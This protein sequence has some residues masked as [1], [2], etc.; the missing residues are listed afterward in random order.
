MK[1]NKSKYFPWI[2]FSILKLIFVKQFQNFHN[3]IILFYLSL[4]MLSNVVEDN[5]H[6]SITRELN[7][8]K[9][10]WR[11]QWIKE[12]IINYHRLC[13]ECD[14]YADTMVVCNLTILVKKI[15]TSLTNENIIKRRYQIQCTRHVSEITFISYD[16]D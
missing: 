3:Y 6:A 8:D 14:F 5:R 7:F 10:S 9:W 1:S 15:E 11:R 16:H 4:Q 2:Y 13:Q 12:I